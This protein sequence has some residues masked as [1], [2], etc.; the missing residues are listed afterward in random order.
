MDKDKKINIGCSAVL[1][2]AILS[3]IPSAIEG[4]P[5]VLSLFIIIFGVIVAYGISSTMYNS[6]S[7][8]KSNFPIIPDD[9]NKENANHHNDDIF[10]SKEET[11]FDES[12]EAPYL[13]KLGLENGCTL[14]ELYKATEYIQIYSEEEKLFYTLSEPF[15]LSIT[16]KA[17]NIPVVYLSNE[18][19][20][21]GYTYKFISE[22]KDRFCVYEGL[23]DGNLLLFEKRNEDY[24]D[25]L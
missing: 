10:L 24:W 8:N 6:S 1:F 15:I 5:P 22:H 9:G 7:K 21:N 20:E 14:E 16:C 11:A 2:L 13:S 19:K 23:D 18:V 3:G 4:K 17:E 25:E 12:K